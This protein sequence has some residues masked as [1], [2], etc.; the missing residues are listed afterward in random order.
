VHDPWFMICCLLTPTRTTAVAPRRPPR[1][2][3]LRPLASSARALRAVEL[4]E[5]GAWPPTPRPATG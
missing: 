5:S 3:V 2:Q 4:L 1:D